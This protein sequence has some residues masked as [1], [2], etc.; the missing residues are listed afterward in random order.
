[1]CEPF[2]LSGVRLRDGLRPEAG[3]AGREA[4]CGL[5]GRDGEGGGSWGN[6]G[7]P[8]RLVEVAPWSRIHE[9]RA[10]VVPRDV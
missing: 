5:S 4:R 6:H 1:M 7:V 3:F 8:P 2:D 10:L 9:A